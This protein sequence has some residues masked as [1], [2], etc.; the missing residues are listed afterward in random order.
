MEAFLRSLFPRVAPGK[1]FEIHAFQGKSDLLSKLEARL[2]GYACWLPPVWRIVVLVDRDEQDCLKLK[3]ELEGIARRAMLDTPSTSERWQVVHRIAVEELEAW[4]F[5]DWDAV[6]AAYP[7]APENIRRREAFRDP[8]AIRGGTWEALERVLQRAGYFSGGLPKGELA[9]SIARHFE[10][11]RCG[12]GSF[13]VF[14]R[15]LTKAWE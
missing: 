13:G 8:D 10:P 9:R 4:Y 15:V 7:R 6:R 1:S 5:G 12:S 2:R 3:A 14:W 11:A